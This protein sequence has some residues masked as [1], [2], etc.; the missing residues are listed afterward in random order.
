LNTPC[1][2][3]KSLGVL[4]VWAVLGTVIAVRFFTWEPQK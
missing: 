4:A 1:I 3:A 2:E